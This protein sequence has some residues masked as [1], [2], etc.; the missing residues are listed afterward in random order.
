VKPPVATESRLARVD[1]GRHL[2]KGLIEF[3]EVIGGGTDGGEA[4]ALGL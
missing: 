4:G 2:F 1:L 3:T